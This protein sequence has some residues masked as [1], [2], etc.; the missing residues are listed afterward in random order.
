MKQI[1]LVAYREFLTQ[2][3]NKSF[4]IMTIMSPL[5]I[6]LA[7]AAIVWFSVIN[8]QH[9]NIAVVDESSLFITSFKSDA[10]TS[11]S[12]YSKDEFNSIKDTLNGSE[13][14]SAL[15]HIPVGNETNLN[16]IKTNTQLYTNGNLGM[17]ER[18]AIK[19]VIDKKIEEMELHNRGVDA[20]AIENSK[21]NIALK[22]F[23]V[24]EGKE[25]NGLAVKVGLSMF[26]CYIIFMFIMIYGVRVMRSVVEEK[27]NRV[28]EIIISSVKPFELMMGKILGTTMVATTQFIIWIAM[29]L[30][31]ALAFP[32]LMA[33]RIEMNQG[34]LAANSDMENLTNNSDVLEQINS[35]S[36]ALLDLNYPLIIFAFIG[37]FIL[38][39]L[40]YSSIFAA[41]GS[42]VDNDTDTQQ[43]TFLP[44]V[45]MMIGL[46]GSM[47]T[48]QNPDG[49]VA[50]WLSMFPLTSPISMM[51]RLP[52]DVP[53][54]QILLSLSI[55]AISTILMIWIAAR[56]Y[57]V[58]IL[59]FGKKPSL[60]EMLKWINYKN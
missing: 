19:T 50:F 34:S 11:Y 47:S 8:K 54:W 9:Q 51:T 40:F 37:F 27:Q 2:I 52:Y 57:R 21:S 60:K 33:S 53:F 30:I 59:M 15:L 58:G 25:D 26:L 49:P 10:N 44:L 43:F 29:T 5:L 36:M 3:K 56:I 7:I 16:A 20:K 14:V 39:Y 38:G 42:A 23:N 4:I 31:L 28:V 18:L 32:A 1:L 48:V 24:K 35:V 17:D 46:Y 12:F 45:P 13:Y 55:L 6:I 22:I 41:I